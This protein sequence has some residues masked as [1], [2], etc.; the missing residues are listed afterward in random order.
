MK[1]YF[2]NE[3]ILIGILSIFF[4]PTPRRCRHHHHLLRRRRRCQH[5]INSSGGKIPTLFY[6]LVR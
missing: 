2:N 6:T 5:G 3:D 4:S 1:R